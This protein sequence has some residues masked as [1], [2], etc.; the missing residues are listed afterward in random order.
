MIDVEVKAGNYLI[1]KMCISRVS[2]GNDYGDINT[3]TVSLRL[4]NIDS[5]PKTAVFQH[6]Y[7]DEWPILIR[8]ALE[9]VGTKAC[10]DHK[11]KQPSMER[12]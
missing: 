6:R 12:Q 2:G 5:M 9:A 11:A 10:E 8:K 7:G 4:H 1:G 3:Y